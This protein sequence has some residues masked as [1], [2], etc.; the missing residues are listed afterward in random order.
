MSVHSALQL[1]SALS[2]AG[3]GSQEVEHLWACYEKAKAAE[4]KAGF[5]TGQPQMLLAVTATRMRMLLSTHA[6]CMYQI[7][8][9]PCS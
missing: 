1:L 9:P 5:N 4:E 2:D 7:A 3:L 6:Y 8:A